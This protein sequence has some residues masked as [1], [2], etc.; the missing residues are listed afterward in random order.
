MDFE[1]E[2]FGNSSDDGDNLQDLENENLEDMFGS[3]DEEVYKERVLPSFKKKT[4][5][6]KSEKKVVKK[7]KPKI[8]V[9]EEHVQKDQSPEEQKRE[10]ARQDFDE[11]LERIKP[12]GRR[13]DLKDESVGILFLKFRNGMRK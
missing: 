2:I 4:E 12:K 5:I 8:H 10:Q 11:A 13:R 3:S 9:Q 1:K 7:R 6:E